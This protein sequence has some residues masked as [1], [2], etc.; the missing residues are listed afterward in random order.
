MQY[1]GPTKDDLEN[2]IAL[3]RYFLGALQRPG[4]MAFAAPEVGCLPLSQRARVAEAPF[5]L[6]SL[7]EQDGELWRQL[8]SQ[9]PQLELAPAGDPAHVA[10]QELTFASLSFLWQL[11]RRNAYAARIVSGAPVDFCDRL[12][13]T[14]LVELLRKAAGRVDLLVPRFGVDDQIWCRLVTGGVRSERRLQTMSQ[15][16][17]LQCLLTR[18]QL[19]DYDELPAAASRFASQPKRRSGKRPAT[20]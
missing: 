12:V 4:A 7:Q 20:G 6:F 2:V 14:T 11:S 1:Q 18:G 19:N 5:L 16:S 15:Q 3:N 10:I 17:A 8:L 13:S 9:N